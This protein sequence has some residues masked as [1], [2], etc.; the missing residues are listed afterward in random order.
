VSEEEALQALRSLLSTFLSLARKSGGEWSLNVQMLVTEAAQASLAYRLTWPDLARAADEQLR[1]VLLGDPLQPA[2][3]VTASFGMALAPLR[4]QLGASA[5]AGSLPAGSSSP[6]AETD[7]ID[8][9]YAALVFLAVLAW[10][11]TF[12]GPVVISKLPSADQPIV[13][14]YWSAVPGIAVALT[15]AILAQRKRK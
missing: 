14:D 1:V 2:P 13:T 6:P 4:M 10:L 12:V 5:D 3:H 8:Y 7:G 15:A 9:Q 11:V